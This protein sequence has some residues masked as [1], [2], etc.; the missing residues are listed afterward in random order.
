MALFAVY[1]LVALARRDPFF[2]RNGF[3]LMAGFCALERFGLEFL[4]PYAPLLGPFTLFH[5]ATAALLT[6]ALTMIFRKSDV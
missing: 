6:Y 4:K 3:Y 5:L 1:A 2:Q